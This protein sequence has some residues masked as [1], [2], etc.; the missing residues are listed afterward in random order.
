MRCLQCQKHRG[1]R[2]DKTCSDGVG[3]LAWPTGQRCA[4]A[5][6]WHVAQVWLTRGGTGAVPAAPGGRDGGR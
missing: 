4:V 1:L 2:V 3:A 6:S 5:L